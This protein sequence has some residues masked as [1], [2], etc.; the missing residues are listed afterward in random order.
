MGDRAMCEIKMEKGSI[1]FYTHWHG[2]SLGD[3]AEDALAMAQPRINDEPYAVRI[4]ID[5]LIKNAGGRDSET[6]SGIMLAP[7]AEDEYNG[8]EPSVIINLA[9]NYVQTDGR[10]TVRRN[11]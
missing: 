7:D 4:I 10:H 2:F 11:F 6:G 9:E 3:I 1:Y 5:Q 8:D